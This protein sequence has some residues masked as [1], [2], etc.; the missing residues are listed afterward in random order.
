MRGHAAFLGLIA[1]SVMGCPSTVVV[2][3]ITVVEDA[4]ADAS[5]SVTARAKADF[6]CEDIQLTLLEVHPAGSPER[7]SAAGCGKESTYVPG[8]SGWV[9]APPK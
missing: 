3:G 6:A 8:D 5:A 4:W 7:V 1:V 2:S 9:P